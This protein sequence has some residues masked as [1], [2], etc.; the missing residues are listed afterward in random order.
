MS[1]RR[2]LNLIRRLPLTSQV[3]KDENGEE[4]LWG[5]QEHLLAYIADVVAH[6]DWAFVAANSEGRTGNPPEPFPRPGQSQLDRE[7]EAATTDDVKSFL[8]GF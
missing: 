6:L 2:V 1:T 4:A 5:Y 8:A 3:S 7:I